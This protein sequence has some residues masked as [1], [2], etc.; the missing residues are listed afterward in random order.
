MIFLMNTV[1]ISIYS[2]SKYYPANNRAVLSDLSLDIESGTLTALL[3][4]SGSGKTTLL[5]LIAGL[6]RPSSGGISLFGKSLT[7][8]SDNELSDFRL[9]QLG[10]VYQTPNLLPSLTA[11][12]NATLPGHFAKN[13]SS[14]TNKRV[15]ELFKRFGIEERKEAYPNELSGGELQRVSLA[16]ALCNSPKLLLADEPTGDLDSQTGQEIIQLLRELPKQDGVTVFVATH[17]LELGE[18]ADRK[19]TLK[20]GIFI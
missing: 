10:L 3:G 16:R 11:F 12:E 18:I 20:D 2:L 13:K 14:F 4:K 17:D 9:S 1:A 19:L 7:E 5:H 6:D 15:L 8:A